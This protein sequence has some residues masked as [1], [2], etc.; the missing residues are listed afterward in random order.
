VQYTVNLL[1]E[2]RSVPSF[3]YDLVDS[4]PLTPSLPPSS[5]QKVMDKLTALLTVSSKSLQNIVLHMVTEFK[6]GLANDGES[7]KMIPS[8]VTQL[9]TGDETGSVL[10]LDMGGS[11][12]RV[13]HASLEGSGRIR[14]KQRK[15]AL[16]EH[17]KQIDGVKLFDFFAECVANFLI[18]EK[19]GPG[20]HSLG[21]TF[22]FPVQQISINRGTLIHWAKG[23]ENDG[24][25]GKD[26]VILLEEAFK[27]KGVNIKV[28]ALVNDT[29]GTLVTHAY[30]DPH[31]YVA[32]ILGTGTN[33][34]YVER[35]ANI[36]KWDVVDGD[37]VINTEWGA[38]GEPSILPI[39]PYDHMLDRSSENPKKQLFEKMIS[40]LYM[41]ELTRIIMMD[42]V[43]S[44]QLFKGIGSTQLGTIHSFDTAYMSRIERYTV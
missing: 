4:R 35:A 2:S 15:Y 26:V 16:T 44:G 30:R 6:K 42:L 21:F 38:Y 11:N 43:Q 9:P 27:R 19:C 22:S 12:F 37:V 34:A 10:A 17:Y 24:V 20:P 25:V 41:G 40:G 14:T 7:L 29:V 36:P 3:Q 39:T 31:T 28:S 5:T 13:L 18:D 1:I 8:Y 23:F 32:V 33:A